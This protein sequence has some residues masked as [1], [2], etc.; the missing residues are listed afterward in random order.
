MLVSLFSGISE[1]EWIGICAACA[2][3]WI[4][5]GLWQGSKDKEKSIRRDGFQL[6]VSK[7][8]FIVEFI[9]WCVGHFGLPPQVNLTSSGSSLVQASQGDG[10]VS[11]A[12]QVDHCVLE[13][14]IGFAE[15]SKYADSR[16][17]ALFGYPIRQA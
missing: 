11:A 6:H 3:A 2:A 16:V 7:A 8:A 5:W 10:N 14:P 12:T 15:G 9:R 1:R 4:F 17:P 13:K